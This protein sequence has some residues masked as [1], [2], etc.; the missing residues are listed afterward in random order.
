MMDKA[1]DANAAE[2]GAATEHDRRRHRR[3]DVPLRARFL[4]DRGDERAGEVLNISAGGA[5]IRAKHP[6]SVGQ[7]VILYVDR[8][9][10]IEAE[11][12]RSGPNSF[13]VSYPQRRARQA[14]L[15]DQLTEVL[16]N[17][18]TGGDR[19]V[20]PRIRQDAPA[21]VTLEDGREAPCSIQDISLTGAS[22]EI[23]PRP[24]LGMHLVLGRMTA[25]VVRRHETGVGVV[26]TG[27][28]RNM[29]EV[30]ADASEANSDEQHG[31]IVAR[32]FG[33]KA[34]VPRREE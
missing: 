15:A 28:A 13:A 24:P 17:R 5:M 11:V 12:V 1:Q 22:L 8:I 30:I 4:T 7:R 34:P 25:K 23:S 18:R 32:R 33:R 3:V 6:P 26:F 14:R 31:S 9:G 2:P 20:N 16:D 10:R 21:M 27:S 29:E 19:R